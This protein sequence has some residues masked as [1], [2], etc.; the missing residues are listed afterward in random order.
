MGNT[1]TSPD[2]Q[3]TLSELNQN[4]LPDV[5]RNT[6]PELPELPEM[7]DGPDSWYN[8]PRITEDARN[9]RL[10][11]RAH[12]QNAAYRADPNNFNRREWRQRDEARMRAPN[13]EPR[14]F[15]MGIPR[16]MNQARNM[17]R[18]TPQSV[19]ADDENDDAT[20]L[21]VYERGGQAPFLRTGELPQQTIT[22][23]SFV[24]PTLQNNRAEPYT[25]DSDS[26]SSSDSSSDDDT[27]LPIQPYPADVPSNSARQEI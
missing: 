26:D 5:N 27:L 7:E 4:P 14:E 20:R 9:I 1:N 8:D 24:P 25:L 11:A 21:E 22:I 3:N 23:P 16:Q 10:R 2:N 17:R 15:P 13:R 18:I 6:L 19:Q 12:R